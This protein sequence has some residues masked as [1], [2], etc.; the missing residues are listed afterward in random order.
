VGL[1]SIRALGSC[2]AKNT[3]ITAMMPTINRGRLKSFSNSVLLN[4]PL[5]AGVRHSALRG[6][7]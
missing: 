6:K 2:N 5:D 4:K 3:V 7:P 1:L